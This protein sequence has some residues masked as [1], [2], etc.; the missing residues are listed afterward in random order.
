MEKIY[1]RQREYICNQK[2]KKTDCK[3][4]SLK[5]FPAFESD[6]GW[7]DEEKE[8]TVKRGK[9][10]IESLSFEK[11]IKWKLCNKK[12]LSPNKNWHIFSG[13]VH[14]SSNGLFK[15]W[16]EFVQKDP[17]FWLKKNVF[18]TKDKLKYLRL[19]YLKYIGVRLAHCWMYFPLGHYY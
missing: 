12:W 19:S 9:K 17:H 14:H 15:R 3:T 4:R 11:F 18:S 13:S 1:I 5:T 8:K 2:K 6:D 10:T 16:T 7:E